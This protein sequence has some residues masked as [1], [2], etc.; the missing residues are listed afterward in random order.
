MHCAYRANVPITSGSHAFV[1]VPGERRLRVSARALPF[2]T[3]C[4][5]PHLACEGRV[6]FAGELLIGDGGAL[7]A[8]SNVSGTYKP[9]AELAAQVNLPVDLLW[10][11]VTPAELLRELGPTAVVH[12]NT[13]RADSPGASG[14]AQHRVGSMRALNARYGIGNHYELD[15][16]LVLVRDLVRRPS[17]EIIGSGCSYSGGEEGDYIADTHTC[18]SGHDG[19]LARSVWSSTQTS[20]V[21]DNTP[22]AQRSHAAKAN[23][24]L[25][26]KTMPPK[27]DSHQHS[28]SYLCA[29]PSAESDATQ[30]LIEQATP[31]L[32]GRCS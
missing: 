15:A 23:G 21:N 19:V 14:G 31:S 18:T 10:V 12:K 11:V 26:R 17:A 32:S 25:A 20:S 2:G 16:G 27:F 1:L 3:A 4:G 7:L 29:W 22:R 24:R 5:H 6:L 28:V 30:Q 8:W 13:S 9:P